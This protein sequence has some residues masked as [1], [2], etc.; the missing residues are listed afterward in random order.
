MSDRQ[1][2]LEQW[3]FPY[4]QHH[5]VTLVSRLDAADCLERIYQ[6]SC[7]FFGYD[8]FTLFADNKIQ[9]HLEW[10]P[11]WSAGKRPQLNE[12]LEQVRAHPPEITHYEF[13]FRAD[14]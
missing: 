9:P 1:D 6:E 10:S 14:L 7:D 4:T 2:L 11:S 5:G 3:Q 12:V 13:V 8:S